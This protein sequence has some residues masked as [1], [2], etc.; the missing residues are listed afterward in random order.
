MSGTSQPIRVLQLEDSPLDAE[1]VKHKLEVGGLNCH[2]SHSNSKKQFET[3][4]AGGAFDIILCDYKLAGYDGI[5]ALALAKEK[6]PQTPVIMISGSLGEEEAV[7][8]LQLGATDYL[9]KQRLERLVPAVK[10][11]LHEAAELNRRRQ[12]EQAQRASEGRCHAVWETALDA[13]RLTDENGVIISVNTAFCRLV[14]MEREA[15]EGQPFA[16]AYTDRRRPEELLA[17]YR[18]RFLARRIQQQTERRVVLR[19]SRKVDLEISSTFI[20]QSGQPP[21]LLG[22]FRDITERKRAAEQLADSERRLRTI[23]ESEPECVKLLG[24]N[25]TLL[26][27]NPAGLRMIDADSFA[28]VAG[29]SVLN[30]IMPS[31]RD[32]FAKLSESVLHGESGTLEFEI[33]GLKGTHRWMETHAVPMHNEQGQVTSALGITRDTTMRKHAEEAL[34]ESEQ[35]LRAV[36]E[37]A[38]DAIITMDHEGRIVEFNSAAEEMFGYPRLKVIGREIGELIIPPA[39]RERHRCGLAQF[40][41]KGEGQAL[42]R[43]LELPALRMD[44]SEFPIELS[45]SRVGQCEP[46]LFTGF[47]RDITE[48]KQA[49]ESLRKA[50]AKYRSIFDN[51]VE[52][53]LQTTP[54]GRLITANAALARMLGYDSAEILLASSLSMERDVYLNPGDRTAFLRS[55]EENEVSNGFQCQFKRKDGKAIWVSL[56]ARVARDTGG[57]QFYEAT[58]VDITE[59]KLAADRVHEQAALLDQARDAILVRDLNQRITYWNKGAERL[60]GWTAEEALGQQADE[61]F[62]KNETKFKEEIHR[63][64]IEK[65]EW[66]G[67]LTQFSKSGKPLIVESR[68]TL[69][70]DEQGNPKLILVIN[71][72]ITQRKRVEEQMLRTQRLESLGNLAGGVAHDLNN[73]LAPIM[74][75]VELLRLE[76]PEAKGLID[77]MEA[78]AQRGA[79]MVRQLLTFA[80]GV[81]GERLLIQPQHL[82]KEMQKI[83]QSTFPKNIQL[84][85]S[86]TKELRAVRGDATQLHQ[87]LLNLCVNARDAM[88]DGGTLTLETEN[89]EIDAAYASAVVGAKPGQYVVW[90]VV[91]T[92]T[93]IPQ[94]TLGHIFEPFFSTKGP[95]RGTGL[96]LSTVIGIVKSHGGFIQVYSQ[97]GQGSTFSV[98][99]PSDSGSAAQ[100]APTPAQIQFQGQGELVLVVDDEVAVREVTRSVLTALNFRVLTAADGTEAL[101]KVAE[102]RD[103]LRAVITDLHMPHMDGLSF[104]RVLK[105]MLPRAGIIVTSGRLVER[106]ESEFKTLGVSAMITKPFPQE[107][108]AEALRTIFQK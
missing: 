91:D 24:P 9:L 29:Q 107:K 76:Y 40:L 105:R 106:D 98:Y 36:L 57:V 16:V 35:R 88:P 75:G 15:L 32:A 104:V 74:M 37:S 46:P 53:I 60:Y 96:G 66:M 28:Q 102:R 8:C 44:G 61:L 58:C 83:I 82:F 93:G 31:Y 51:A 62:S 54:E 59:R 103:E 26:E 10:R 71:T 108:L 68:R 85:T 14:G 47:I 65:G 19:S 34:R 4:L 23:I 20:E 86:S 73:T 33:Q 21:L 81:E 45:I 56:N 92:G 3:A 41:P 99:L 72:D 95:D 30:L 13:M 12:A 43:R 22:V 48:R 67:E 78:S 52:G 80:K 25:C 49:E 101:M 2:I 77:T 63:L 89:V 84:R 6:H 17:R 87:V 69:L 1:I 94:E 27:M 7:R 11:A 97:P 5:S 64:V 50:E 55:I 42:N 100:L 39:L 70:C 18:E 90:R 38:L 79:G